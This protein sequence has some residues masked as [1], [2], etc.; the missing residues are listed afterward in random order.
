GDLL[1]FE[2]TAG[3]ATIPATTRYPA[4]AA[5]EDAGGTAWHHAG[6]EA[7]LL[8][9]EGQAHDQSAFLEGITTPALFGAAVANMGVLQLLGIIVD[10]A[11]AAHARTDT[12]GAPRAVDSPF[13]GFVFKVQ[14]GMNPAHRDRL[15]FIRVC[16]GVFE[17][18]MNLIHEPSGRP[19]A[20]KYA[21]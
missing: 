10:C 15:A 18:G 14:A 2:R 19:F 21:Q 13:S 17:R 4:G 6:E 20:T 8:R 7:E 11:P 16:S 3:G 5:A 12:T 9:A 1:R